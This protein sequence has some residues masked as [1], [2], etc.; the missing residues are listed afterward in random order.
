MKRAG[1][2][3]V[4]LTLAMVLLF[5]TPALASSDSAIT[6]KIGGESATVSLLEG[7]VWLKKEGKGPEQPIEKG[8]RVF[9]GD[10][11]RTGDG[12]RLELELPEGSFLRFDENTSFTVMASAYQ[13]AE[14]SRDIRIRMILGKAW[15]RVSRLFKGR[16]RFALETPTAVAGV[17]GTT[18]R[19]NL[20]KD[21]SAVVKVYD[22]EVEVR[23]RM[24]EDG[25]TPGPAPLKAPHP[26]AGPRPVTME[27]WV[28]IVGAL[29]QINIGPDGTATEPFRFDIQADL[30]DWV[31]WNQMRDQMR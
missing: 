14:E 25:P 29:Q 3:A 2:S 26:V 13:Q 11:V 17:R 28:Y 24:T 16:G 27:E 21:R 23:R 22:G 31:R 15:A 6:V 20:E 5:G 18:Y 10:V 30:D 7:D 1:K 9:A 12:S 4:L 19:L 8:R